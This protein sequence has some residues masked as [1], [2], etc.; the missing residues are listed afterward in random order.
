[1]LFQDVKKRISYDNKLCHAYVTSGQANVYLQNLDKLIENLVHDD[2]TT[3]AE[4]FPRGGA[5]GLLQTGPDI[6][7]QCLY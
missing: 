2:L 7:Q 5:L 4:S 3:I 6:V 1:M